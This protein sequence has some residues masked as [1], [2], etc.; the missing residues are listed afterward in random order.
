MKTPEFFN[1]GWAQMGTD[2]RIG[3]RP[4]C[5]SGRPAL[6]GGRRLEASVRGQAGSLTSGSIPEGSSKV[7]R[8]RMPPGLT[9][10]I[11][12]LKKASRRDASNVLRRHVNAGTQSAASTPPGCDLDHHPRFPLSR[13]GARCASLPLATFCHPSGMPNER[14]G[15]QRAKG[16]AAF[17]IRHSAFIILSA[18]SPS[19]FAQ[20]QPADPAAHTVIVPYDP[21]KPLEE[22]KAERFYLGYEEFQRLWKAAKENRRPMV[23]ADTTQHAVIHSAL[24]QGRI[25]ERGLVLE[26]R[27]TAT[28]R[29]QWSKLL[30][31]FVQSVGGKDHA[32]ALVGEVRVD[33]KSAALSNSFLTLEHPGAH[34]IEL[35]ATLPLLGDWNDLT[36]RLPPSLSGMLALRTPKSDGWLRVNGE[37]ASTVEEQAE[38]RLFTQ[39][40]GTHRE[41][42]LQRSARG[43]E[44][45]EGPVAAANVRATLT[46]REL[47][48]ESLDAEVVYEFPGSVRRTLEFAVDA[49]EGGGGLEI[50]ALNVYTTIPGAGEVRVPT[51]ATQT[52]REGGK[53]IFTLTLRHEVSHGATIRIAKAQ[54]YLNATGVRALPLIHPLAQR[55]KQDVAVLHDDSMKVQVRNG[56]AQRFP[57]SERGALQDAGRWQWNGG[58][59]PTYEVQ[60]AALFAEADV[61]YV[62]QLSEQKAELLAALTLKRKRGAWTRAVVGLPAD[63]EVQAVQGPALTAWQHEGAQ[64]YLHLDPNIAAQEARLVVHLARVAPQAVTTWKLEPLELE[65]Y[66]KV[67]GK[68]LIVAH[69][70]NEVKLPDLTQRTD[71]KELDATVL[72]SV[73]AI[74]PPMEK[75]R[76]VQHEGAVW[77]VDVALTRQASRYS[78]DAVLLV[79]ASD[80]GIRVSQQVA[81]VVEQGALRQISV[82]LPATLPE[83]VVSGSLL[84]ETRSRIEGAERVYECSFQ[85]EVLDRAELTFDLDLPLTAELDVPFVK[86][87]GASR[88][89]RWFVL[90]NGSARE[91]KIVNQTALEAAAREAV[92]YL[93]QGLARP[94]FFR[95]TGDGELKLAYQQLTSTEGNAALVTLAD[96]TTILRADGERWDIAQY[97]LINRSLQFL[98]VILPEGTELISVSVSG[99]PVRADEETQDGKRVRLIPLIHTRPGQRALEVKMIYRFA[100]TGRAE[101][102]TTNT[103]DDPELVG[104]SVERTTWT[105]WTPK[106]FKLDDFDGNMTATVEE[107]RELQRLEGMLSELGEVNRALSSGKLDYGDAEAAYRDANELA[108]KVQA[109]KQEIVTKM[110]RGSLI[111]SDSRYQQGQMDS[112]VKQQQEL[113]KGNWDN[114]YAGKNEMRKGGKDSGLIAKGNTFW[115]L[116][117]PAMPQEQQVRQ[118]GANTFSGAI[119]T[120]GAQLFNDNVAVDNTYFANGLQPQQQALAGSGAVTLMAG[121][122][123]TRS[124]QAAQPMAGSG[125]LVKSGS[126]TFALSGVNTYTGSTAIN[127]GTTMLQSGTSNISSNARGNNL[128]QTQAMNVP[129]SSPTN[130]TVGALGGVSGTG[131]LFNRA[132]M[133][134]LPGHGTITAPAA[135]AM[136]AD[137]FG[138]PAAALPPPPPAPVKPMEL[139]ATGDAKAK[140]QLGDLILVQTVESLRPTGRR[141]LEITLPMDG[142]VHHFSKLKDHAVLEIE[143]ER[144]GDAKTAGRL[145]CLTGGLLLW[146][147]VWWWTMKRQR[148]A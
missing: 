146:L 39:T 13:G 38:G 94:Q 66:E 58:A 145:F 144:L 83:A 143:I 102:R 112:E 27:I 111:L 71:L 125:G 37:A 46:L 2:R 23:D 25:E 64:L 117:S 78:V 9:S 118:S 134:A 61:G 12:I 22:Q 76:A 55:V 24:Y 65:N 100:T 54:R 82:R 19:L 67:G 14:G 135:P 116:N 17:V 129:Q 139:P 92:P 34:A 141:A 108:Q 53:L 103:L 120:N 137:P 56:A 86:V 28:T 123:I 33:G 74:A 5:G 59:A 10:E 41:M 43:L 95:A 131:V 109:K 30:L 130:Q 4:V 119:T 101:A 51:N 124:G 89:T 121:N 16:F 63:Y 88:L 73:F 29:G 6:I 128:S 49:P 147:G 72:D 98:P 85:T 127:G 60:P 68:A 138:V 133:T 7:A 70:A 132:D 142:T 107:G 93:P 96:L 42:H 115:D 114:N 81:A 126:G 69:A 31:P 11:V 79:L 48:P 35:T 90:D 122:V 32:P 44:R 40:L 104:L 8:G 36:L 87:P 50:G 21:K 105:V 3:L 113:L 20:A 45:G 18:L 140:E 77:N 91:A 84:R 15:V 52:R 26:A 1:H 47:E 136:S 110:G 75:K 148:T 62:F 97:S 106:G 57:N 80:A 99:E